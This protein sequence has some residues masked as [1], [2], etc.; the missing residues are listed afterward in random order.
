MSWQ[1]EAASWP[2]L[3][4]QI[5]VGSVALGGLSKSAAIQRQNIM[6]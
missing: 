6:K 5:S 1:Q 4:L 3:S 2:D